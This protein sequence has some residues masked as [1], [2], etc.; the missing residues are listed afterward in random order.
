MLFRSWL[1]RMCAFDNGMCIT[2]LT[3]LYN[4]TGEKKYLDAAERMA[5]WLLTVMRRDDGSY[6]SKFN[7]ADGKPENPGGKWS[8]ISGSYLSKL[9]I[10][11]TAL[12]KA[13]NDSNYEEAVRMLCAWSLTKQ[14]SDGR[15]LTDEDESKTFVHPH[16][17]SAEGL[18]VSGLAFKEPAWIDAARKAVEWIAPQQLSSGGFP[19]YYEDGKFLEIE[20]PDISAQVLRLWLLLP[21]KAGTSVDIDGVVR[22]IAS[23]QF[24]SQ[25]REEAGGIA[26]GPAW[27]HGE[28]NRAG[29]HINSWVTMFCAQTL[30]LTL[31]EGRMEPLLLV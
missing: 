13:T 9:A 21:D 2:G 25:K 15:F 26:S 31:D 28:E 23:F 19:A 14:Q 27:F 16:C 6:F 24:S 10:G 29:Q 20:S 11:F 7:V 18:L 22:N 4:K 5:D 3:Y 1:P 12:H 17:Y 8:L 30:G